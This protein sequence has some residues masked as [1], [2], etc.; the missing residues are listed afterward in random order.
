VAAIG[1]VVGLARPLPS[2]SRPALGWGTGVRATVDR[3]AVVR[4]W[5]R[6]PRLYDLITLG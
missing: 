5:D 4:A 1:A 6:Q 2:P 3:A